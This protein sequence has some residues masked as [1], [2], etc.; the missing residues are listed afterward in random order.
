MRNCE[1]Q[2]PVAVQAITLLFSVMKRT[3]LLLLALALSCLAMVACGGKNS[4]T[5]TNAGTDYAAVEIPSFCADSAYQYCA[6]QL[7]FGFRNPDSKGHD[8]CATYLAAKMRQWCDTVIVQN[9][10]ATLWNGKECRGKNIIASLDPEKNNRVLLAAHWDSRLWAD[11]DAD[12]ANHKSPILGAND[13]ASGVAAL[14]EMAR[15]MSEK[16]PS[17]G[18]DFIFFDL[19]DQG[20][21]EWADTYKDNTWC[22]GS[23]YWAQY[24]HR[25]FYKAAYGILFDMVG[26]ETAR[27]TKEEVSRSY[28]PG[29]TKKIWDCASALGHGDKFVNQNTD[30]ILD[31]HL[32]I[33]QII[34]IPTADIVQ[35]SVGG[36]FFPYWHT[37]KDNLECINRQSMKAVAD[38]TMAV[39][40]AQ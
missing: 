12:E 5:T 19:E 27:F 21:P 13:G 14:M 7:S 15:V 18:V 3:F 40:Y 11:H 6:D 22:L 8:Q 35:N 34:G 17:M 1:E 16:R 29:L 36:N 2:S 33:N 39:L 31:D 28:A 32:Y 23:Q 10:S 38:V 9:F 20:L 26:T 24:P 4:N 25:P 37:I 30:A